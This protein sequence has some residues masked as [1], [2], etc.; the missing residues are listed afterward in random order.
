MP[1]AKMLK[2]GPFL[3]KDRKAG[4]IISAEELG[5]L[6]DTSVQALVSQRIIEVEG[7][8][9]PG[10]PAMSAADL[11]ALRNLSARFDAFRE[12]TFKQF[13]IQQALLESIVAGLKAAKKPRK[14]AEE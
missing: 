2:D 12:T 14:G 4:D 9:A 3:N 1:S 7:M 8:N 10:G 11:E 6:T 13:A 5:F